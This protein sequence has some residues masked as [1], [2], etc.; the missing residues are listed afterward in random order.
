M[1][2]RMR[3]AYLANERQVS[4]W[5]MKKNGHTSASRLGAHDS[6]P[7]S[8]SCTYC[9]LKS[10]RDNLL[11]LSHFSFSCHHLFPYSLYLSSPP[12]LCH[13]P[14][15]IL[16]PLRHLNKINEKRTNLPSPSPHIRN[17]QPLL[18]LALICFYLILDN[19]M[20]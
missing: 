15:L 20:K 12:T 7:Q 18:H 2:R 14:L 19:R 5:I 13:F 16:L 3:C 10:F 4:N 11:I 17:P 1:C 6:I 8:R 9:Q